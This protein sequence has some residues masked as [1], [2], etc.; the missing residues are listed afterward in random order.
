MQYTEARNYIEF[1]EKDR[2]FFHRVFVSNSIFTFLFLFFTFF[3]FLYFTM[4]SV[5]FAKYFL[6]IVI[7]FL[8]AWI[9][10]SI[11]WMVRYIRYVNYIRFVDDRVIIS[12]YNWNKK[13]EEE[14]NINDLSLKKAKM[15]FSMSSYPTLEFFI[16]R[17]LVLRVSSYGGRFSKYWS[18]EDLDKLYD[19][20]I[21]YQKK[22]LDP[23][24]K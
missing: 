6:G 22:Y 12:H 21:E 9:S 4:G 1:S 18:E 8:S 13:R 17:E 16:K 3:P 2:N 10:D 7:F 5:A 23:Q 15:G 11:Y 19:Y 24:D 20:F 14:F